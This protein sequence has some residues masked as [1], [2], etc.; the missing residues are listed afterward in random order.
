[1]QLNMWV[2]FRCK[3]LSEMGQFY[4]RIN[5]HIKD[6]KKS[7][8]IPIEYDS[9]SNRLKLTQDVRNAEETAVS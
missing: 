2:N 3:F 1:R 8:V 7:A 5:M 9:E 6:R 4:A